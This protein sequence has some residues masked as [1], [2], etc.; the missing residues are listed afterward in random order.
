M[1]S[2]LLR[3]PLIKNV[4]C[5]SFIIENGFHY[6][7]LTIHFRFPK[8]CLT[9]KL[10]PRLVTLL[11]II[12]QHFTNVLIFMIKTIFNVLIEVIEI[13]FLKIYKLLMNDFQLRILI[14]Y[15]LL[16]LL[17][18][19]LIYKSLHFRSFCNSTVRQSI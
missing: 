19:T 16:I 18:Q 10:L 11:L 2:S 6:I 8:P 4:N 15:M 3:L 5:I 9:I 7:S 13:I 1:V 14:H 17:H 12:G